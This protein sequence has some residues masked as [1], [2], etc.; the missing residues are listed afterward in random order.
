LVIASTLP[1]PLEENMTAIAET[2][3][4]TRAA[5]PSA[6]GATRY[7]APAGRV[8]FSAIFI[9]AGFGH[10][11]PQEIAF[12]AQQGVPLANV[13]VPLSG[14]LAIAGGL[15]VLLGY[16]ARVGAALLVLFLVP[17]TFKMHA[18]WTFSDPMMAQ[19]HQAMFLKNLSMLGAALI[20]GRSGAGPMSLDAR[21]EGSAQ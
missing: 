14:V 4:G 16:H 3:A 15:S 19:I 12:A 20:I 8:L 1:N 13:A 11:A 7:L 10:F 6:E 2:Q 17:V 5:T 21:R 18:F 9:M